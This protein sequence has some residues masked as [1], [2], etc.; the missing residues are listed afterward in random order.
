MRYLLDTNSLNINHIQLASKGNEV[1]VLK[2]V[3][4][5]KTMYGST[6]SNLRDV[7]ILYP[8]AKHLR[9]LQILLSH[10][11]DNFGLIRL[12]T[13]EGTADVMMLAYVLAEQENPETLFAE[14]YTIVTQDNALI[15][16]ANRYGIASQALL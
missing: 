11:G 13:C 9:R 16:A 2:E 7:S 12:Y 5:E 6:S 8:E 10:E 1:F 15:E 3:V 4:D 14:Q